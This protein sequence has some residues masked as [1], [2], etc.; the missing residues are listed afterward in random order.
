MQ[1]FIA[2]WSYRNFVLTSVHREFH[3]KYTESLLGGIWSI[4]NPLTLIV[5]YTVVLGNLIRPMLHGHEET[6][7]AFGIYLCAG[8]ITWFLFAEMLGRMT[9]VFLEHGNIIKKANFP[10][11]CLPAIVTLSALINFA[12]LL[13]IYLGFL[14]IIGHWP[15]WLLLAI[16]P[17]LALQILFALGLGILLGTMNV[18][19]RDVGQFTGVFLQ[20]WF[21][22]TPIVYTFS[23]L[24]EKVQ[25]VMQ[26]NPMQPLMSGYQTIFLHQQ[27]PDFISLWPL[28]LLTLLFLLLGANLFL[29]RVGEMVDE[30]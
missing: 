13:L 19:F 6:P 14:A 30:L 23:A 16:I 4:A 24:P 20:F 12:L 28:A 8:F 17:L 5:I 15:G 10:R 29:S 21:W 22:L 2:L 7:F 25:T 3:G 27:M 1:M 9:N 11:I 26:F 18:F